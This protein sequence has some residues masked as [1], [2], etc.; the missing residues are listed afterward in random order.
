MHY[1]RWR[2]YGDVGPVESLVS[3]A[4][5]RLTRTGYVMVMAPSGIGK[6]LEH[7]LVMEH[8]L[9]RSLERWENVHH[10]N[11]IRSDNRPENLE[12]WTKAQPA[13][14]RV[15]DL[16]AWVVEHYPAEVAAALSSG[17]QQS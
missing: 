14:Q 13:G 16:V 8:M 11:G 5:R 17:D 10:I 4:E 9:G 1:A 7:R 3:V 2:S 15:A 6:V 12:L